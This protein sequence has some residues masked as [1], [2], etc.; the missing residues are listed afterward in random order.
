[1]TATASPAS[2]ALPRVGVGVVVAHRGRVL[3]IRRGRP[4]RAGEWSIPGGHLQPGETVEQAARREIAEE[5]GIVLGPL[6]LVA[7][8]DLMERDRRGHL[9]R[10]HLL[11]DF[12]AHAVGGSLRAGD[13][14]AEA[15]WLAPVEALERV[16]W[17]RTREVIREGL[18]RLGVPLT[19]LTCSGAGDP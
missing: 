2:G 15:C 9:Q 11:V 6:L 19:T 10:H 13:D 8:V 1:M 16:A 14:A 18:R 7:V 4:P 5:T 17:G 12:A 3:L